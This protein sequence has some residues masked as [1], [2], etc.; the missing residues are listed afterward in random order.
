MNSLQITTH[1]PTAAAAAAAAAADIITHPTGIRASI[2]AG[3]VSFGDV[4]TVLPFGN[5]LAIVSLT[6]QQI[7][8]SLAHSTNQLPAAGRFLQLAGLRHYHR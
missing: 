3:S 4:I 5:V 7:L 6:G 1:Q 2:N 8:D